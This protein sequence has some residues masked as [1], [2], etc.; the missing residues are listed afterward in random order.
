MNDNITNYST[1][2]TRRLDFVFGIGYDDDIRKAKQLLEDILSADKRVLKD[3][4]PT[5]W[6]LELADSSVNI[7]VRPWAN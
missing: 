6:I 2:P 3:L 4:E 5:I 1:K 7:A